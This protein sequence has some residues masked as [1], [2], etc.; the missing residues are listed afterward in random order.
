MRY[1]KIAIVALLVLSSLS[2][3]V[4]RL[5]VIEGTIK[6]NGSDV[7]YKTIGEGEPL[8][9]V[10][11]GPVLDHSYLLPHFEA[12]SKDYKLIFYD[13]RAAG[14]SSIRVD[15]GTMTLDGFVEDIEI[16]RETLGLGK[17]NL[18]AHSWGGLIAMKYALKYDDNL[19]H[20]VLSNA[21][22]PS[23]VDWQAESQLVGQKTSKEDQDKLN[24]L[25]SSGLLRTE[26]PSEAIK[27][28]MMI[29]YRVHMYDK[30]NID[31]LELFIPKDFVLRSQ[32]YGTLNADMSGYDLYDQLINIKTPTLIMFGE[33]E[34]A[35]ELHADRMAESFADSEL[36][37][38]KESGHFPFV[39]SSEEYFGQ[40][41]AFLAK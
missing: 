37:V 5:P 19:N 25:T 10:H 13:Q 35:L 17:I 12:L 6:I 1:F 24:N 4:D 7:Y 36:Y 28:M 20:L 3:S 9:I 27:E 18:L 21:M 30:A 33:I 31:K 34:P 26:D 23:A 14:K 41:K 2:C 39:E 38:V 11:G 16:L 40:V 32:A 22:A 8:V 29:S 15:P